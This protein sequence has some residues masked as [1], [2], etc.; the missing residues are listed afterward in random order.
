MR[1][2]ALDAWALVGYML[3]QP[4]ADTVERWF[5]QAADGGVV[6][7]MTSV[8]WGETVYSVARQH[9]VAADTI[10]ARL[11]ALPIEVVAV[12]RDL[13]VRA[14]SLKAEHGLGYADSFAAALAGALAAP[15]MTGDP[16]FRRLMP[17]LELVWLGE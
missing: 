12:D 7:A 10:V 5:R 14:A 13:A 2:V 8:N 9:A 4:C 11:D 1:A 3:D 15:L 6:L 17:D 16:D